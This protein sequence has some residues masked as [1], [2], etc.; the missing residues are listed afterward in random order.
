MLAIVNS[1]DM[2]GTLLLPLSI[3][4][5]AEE[6]ERLQKLELVLRGKSSTGYQPGQQPLQLTA[7]TSGDR[8][9]Q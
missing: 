2:Q 8:C 3:T 5:T 7:A 6:A 9:P 1:P 4:C